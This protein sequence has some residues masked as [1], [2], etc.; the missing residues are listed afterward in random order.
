MVEESEKPVHWFVR[1]VAETLLVLGIFMGGFLVRELLPPSV[2][3]K[4]EERPAPHVDAL[5]RPVPEAASLLAAA[6]VLSGDVNAAHSHGLST[7]QMA[8]AERRLVPVTVVMHGKVA[9]DPQGVHTVSTPLPGRVDRV[10]HGSPGLFVDAGE[11]LIQL[12]C[13]DTVAAQNALIDAIRAHRETRDSGSGF[14]GKLKTRQIE[15]ARNTLQRMGL[16]PG[17]IESVAGAVNA[18]DHLLFRAPVAGHLTALPV[19]TGQ[20]VAQGDSLCTVADLNTVHVVLTAS[21]Q[22]MLWLRYGQTVRFVPEGRND[23]A[24]GGWILSLAAAADPGTEQWQVYVLALNSQDLLRPGMTVRASV[25]CEAAGVGQI[26]DPNRAESWI[27]PVHP[28][29]MAERSGVCTQCERALVSGSSQGYISESTE[30]ELPLVIPG[31]AVFRRHGQAVVTVQDPNESH[32]E[33]P[34][35]EIHWIGDFVV[36]EQ[37]LNEGDQVVIPGDVAAG[38]RL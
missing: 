36:V 19:H 6:P 37:G 26:V 18:R 1:R 14:F 33:R 4:P 30:A 12:F 2:T 10:Y 27:C 24:W 13:P 16:T 25:T 34:L 29:V 32:Q 28:Q 8:T 38:D 23:L 17:Q 7:L 11:A 5:P 15:E 31:Q 21:Q 9:F 22:D 20:Y 35:G 3:Q